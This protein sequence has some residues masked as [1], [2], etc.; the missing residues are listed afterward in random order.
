M[1]NFID[2]VVFVIC[3]CN[4]VYLLFFAIASLFYKKKKISTNLEKEL[5]IAILIPAYKEDSVILDCV[6]SCLA[7]KYESTHYDV[8]VTSD[9][10][11]DHTNQILRQSGAKVVIAN[12]S[13]STKTKALNLAFESL[14]DNYYDIALILDA[15]N[16]IPQHYLEEL[17]KIFNSGKCN[18]Y[19]THRVEKNFNNKLAYLDAV[20]EEVNNSIFR[21][22]H[23]A[24]GFSSALIGSGMAF[25]YKLIKHYLSQ[26]QAVGGFDR[27]LEF[28]LFKAGEKIGYVEDLLVYDEKISSFNGFSNQRR[29]WMSAQIYYLKTFILDFLKELIKGHFDFCDKLLQHLCFPRILLIGTVSICSILA[30]I[31]DINLGLKWW[32]L[33]AAMSCT[34]L[35][36]IPRRLYSRELL[37]ALLALP[38]TFLVMFS[39]IFKLKNANKR[40]IHTSHGK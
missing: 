13:E 28:R 23:C 33:F 8:I 29:R 17:C 25:D 11:E 24:I 34:I 2:I 16:I 26:M 36:S 18:A 9:Q 19:Q 21:K 27:E 15:D 1:I 38:K 12:Y 5:K 31:I 3:G 32:I 37:K 10:M 14:P 39:N 35:I 6:N 4:V 40:F 20:S 30:T 22:G 7:Q